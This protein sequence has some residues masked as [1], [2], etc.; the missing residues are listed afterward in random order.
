MRTTWTLWIGE[1]R[2]ETPYQKHLA[3]GGSA[4]GRTERLG[5]VIILNFTNTQQYDILQL[6]E[7]QIPEVKNHVPND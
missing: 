2:R 7:I 5:Y 3:S 6:T 4:H 1:V